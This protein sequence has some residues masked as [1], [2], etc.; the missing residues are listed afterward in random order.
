MKGVP[1]G[2]R[3]NAIAIGESAKKAAT[4]HSETITGISLTN[5]PRSIASRWALLSCPF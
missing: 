5:P 4:D 3:A 2:R 1:I